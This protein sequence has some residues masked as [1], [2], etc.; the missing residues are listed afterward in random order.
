MITLAIEIS[1]PSSGPRGQVGSLLAGP[2]VALGRHEGPSRAGF[3]GA[4][5]LGET[6]RHD[7]DLMPA[8]DR[9]CRR[10]A[11]HP[12]EI[13]RIAVSIGPGGF[14]SL[15]IA[16]ATA[17]MIAEATGAVTIPV[18]STL[19]AAAAIDIQA[20]GGLAL[21]CLASKGE[22]AWCE[23]LGPKGAEAG[24]RHGD[25]EIPFGIADAGAVRAL[26]PGLVIA[27]RFFPEQMRTAAEQV[28]ASVVEPVFAAQRLLELAAGAVPV[29]PLSLTPLYPRQA[30][31]V[32]QW[33]ARKGRVVENPPLGAP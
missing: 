5:L 20:Q 13:S 11:V 21:V 7:D 32:T 19:V 29:D 2:G 17:K 15:R 27:D 12:R 31:A 23:V 16:I 10:A 1:N 9:L 6:S 25:P 18:R 22:T 24:L 30:E 28:G 26:R 3:L 4:E 33:Q 8:I 14:T